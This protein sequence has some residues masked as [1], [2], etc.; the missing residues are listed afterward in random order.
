MNE[1]PID[2]S[3]DEILGFLSGRRTTLRRILE[4]QPPS[5]AAVRALSGAEFAIFRDAYALRKEGG[6]FRVAGPVWAV[7]DLMGGREPRWDAAYGVP[8]DRLWARED[9][10]AGW[11]CEGGEP[12]AYDEDGNA[13]PEHVWRRCDRTDRGWVSDRGATIAEWVENGSSLDAI[14][15]KRARD[16][17]R[18]LS[19]LSLEIVSERIERID[20]ITEE[21]CEAEGLD[22]ERDGYEV[23]D[24]GSPLQL[25]PA[26]RFKW[27]REHSAPDELWA[28]NPWVRVLE[29]RRVDPS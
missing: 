4:P 28:F 10:I 3:S 2:L 25:R 16:M 26:Y 20:E 27:D 21:G 9:F 29:L 12:V 6:E 5:A 22:R 14:P 24:V 13:L 11:P 15:W 7:R 8:G 17:P 1:R 18:E 23:D 19:R